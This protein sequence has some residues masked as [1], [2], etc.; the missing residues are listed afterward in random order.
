MGVI[1][2]VC[3]YGHGSSTCGYCSPPGRRSA[4]RSS[5]KFDLDPLQLSCEMIDRGWRRSGAFCYKPDLKRSCCPQYT[6]KLDA[7]EFKPTKSQRK[8]MSRWT[9][10]VVHGDNELPPS[11]MDTDGG[12]PAKKTTKLPPFSLVH[13]VH[14][15]ESDFVRNGKYKHKFEVSLEFASYDVEKFRLFERYQDDIHN[16]DSTPAGFKGFLVETPLIREEIQYGKAPPKHLPTHYGSYHQTYR[17][18]GELIAIGV[19]DILPTCVSSVYFMYDKK[20]ERFSLGKLSAMREAA[21]AQEMHEHGLP[22]MNAQYMGFYIHS[23]PKMRYKGDFAPSYLLDPET[24][25]WHTLESCRPLLEKNRYACFA[26]PEHSIAGPGPTKEDPVPE[27][28]KSVLNNVKLMAGLEN[29]AVLVKSAEQSPEWQNPDI[30]GLLIGGI[31]A[32][33]FE[34]AQEVIFNL[35]YTTR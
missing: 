9:R 34:L 21:L 1:S 25:S 13:A 18:D 28:P 3:P 33:G 14:A 32:M 10:F 5:Y 23:C 15:S 4:T 6:I 2:I 20:W 17:L 29:G 26:H 27:V 30:R 24:Y 12:N 35:M 16:D 7:L 19:I 8:A 31:H 22:N 11:A